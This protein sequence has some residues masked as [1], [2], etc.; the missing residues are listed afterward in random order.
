MRSGR[1]YWVNEALETYVDGMLQ[2]G[3]WISIKIKKVKKKKTFVEDRW[4]HITEK[5][6]RSLRKFKAMGKETLVK[7]IPL[8]VTHRPETLHNCR[9][10]R[11][12]AGQKTGG[13]T[14]VHILLRKP[15]GAWNDKPSVTIFWRS[16]PRCNVCSG[17]VAILVYR[18]SCVG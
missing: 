2:W 3:I 15:C 18:A 6:Y 9:S 17:Y 4:A 12:T 13:W 11:R 16:L 5:K 10:A 1:E 14:T 7:K 8:L